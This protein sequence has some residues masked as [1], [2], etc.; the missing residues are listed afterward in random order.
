MFAKFAGSGSDVARRE[1]SMTKN[2]I[3]IQKIISLDGLPGREKLISSSNSFFQNEYLVILFWTIEA[4][5]YKDNATKWRS[6]WLKWPVLKWMD[7]VSM[8]FA[9][10]NKV[11]LDIRIYITERILTS[12][13]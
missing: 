13:S 8:H 9:N 3:E 2:W 12:H 5:L 6:N 11:N 7:R 4:L 1:P 10:Y